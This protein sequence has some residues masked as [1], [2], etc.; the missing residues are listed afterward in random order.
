M[1]AYHHAQ[2][3]NASEIGRSFGMADTTVRNYL[4]KL[5]DALV[6][7]QL[8]PLARESRQASGKVTQDFHSRFR[9]TARATESSR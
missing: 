5:T 6:V 9:V 3:W 7:R 1:L 4:D 8:K 2:L